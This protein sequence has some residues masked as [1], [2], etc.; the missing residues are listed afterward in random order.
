MGDGKEAPD[1]DGTPEP[2]EAPESMDG[3][4]EP[5]EAPDGKVAPEDM[6]GTPEPKEAPEGKEALDGT[7]E[8]KEAPESMDGTPEPKGP[9]SKEGGR[10][11]CTQIQYCSTDGNTDW[12]HIDLENDESTDEEGAHTGAGVRHVVVTSIWLVMAAYFMM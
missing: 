4:P 3:T 1:I 10:N 11:Q 9:D 2:K 6:D 7:P 5:K 8:P 12:E